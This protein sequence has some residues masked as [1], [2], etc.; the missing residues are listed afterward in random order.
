MVIEYRI[1]ASNRYAI[2]IYKSRL[3]YIR[4]QPNKIILFCIFEVRFSQALL[5][6]FPCTWK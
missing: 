6:L 3:S 4:M 1:A 2:G 5:H